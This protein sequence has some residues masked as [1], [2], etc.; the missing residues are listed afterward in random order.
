MKKIFKNGII[1]SLLFGIIFYLINFTLNKNSIQFM[2]WIYYLLYSIIILSFMVGIFQL[3]LKIKN[4]I[5][6]NIFLVIATI[7]SG[8][9]VFIVVYFFMIAYNPEYIIIKNNKKMVATVVSFHHTYIN[10]YDY[11]NPIMKSTKVIDSEHYSDG[12]HNPFKED[13]DYINLIY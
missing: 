5:K 13:I 2:N 8:I 6:R 3:L 12:S 7:F 11:I 10:Y 9:I 4:K 1:Y